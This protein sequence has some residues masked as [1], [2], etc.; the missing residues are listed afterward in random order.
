MLT[1]VVP[2]AA[3]LF[4]ECTSCEDTV[5]V[6]GEFLTVNGDNTGDSS[7]CDGIKVVNIRTVKS[8]TPSGVE[9]ALDCVV[10]IVLKGNDAGGSLT[11]LGAGDAAVFEVTAIAV[12]IVG[13]LTVVL[14]VAVYKLTVK[15]LGKDGDGAVGSLNG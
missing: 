10:K 13:A 15:I 14:G 5:F 1:K 2:C 9:L 8:G 7:V 11:A 6:E 12:V 3:G 4:N